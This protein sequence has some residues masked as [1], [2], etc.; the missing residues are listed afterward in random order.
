MHENFYH[1]GRMVKVGNPWSNPQI[2]AKRRYN[3][4]VEWK[5]KRS[6]LE[7]Y[8]QMLSEGVQDLRELID[9]AKV[10]VLNTQIPENSDRMSLFK[11]VDAFLLNK[12]SLK[13]PAHNTLPELL[14][15]YRNS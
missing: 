1:T 10:T 7:I 2:T 12:P 11:I 14:A 13:L 3:R 5:W 9:T 8:K 6:G 4:R 15:R